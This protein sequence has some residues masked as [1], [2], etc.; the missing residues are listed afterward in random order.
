M[1]ALEVL[2]TACEKAFAGP[3]MAVNDDDPDSLGFPDDEDIS[4]P[5]S[6]ITF[7]MIRDARAVL[8]ATVPDIVA[9][10]DDPVELRL[11]LP[12]ETEEWA[13]D[14]ILGKRQDGP[15]DFEAADAVERTNAGLIVTRAV[16]GNCSALAC[17]R[18]WLQEV[19][20]ALATGEIEPGSLI[21][22]AHTVRGGD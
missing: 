4:S 14:V 16:G 12:P 17:A 18:S 21:L 1:N 7:G 11:V 9:Q 13:E 3:G 8:G 19:E 20:D 2:V 22:L 6:G 5:P 15:N 10:R